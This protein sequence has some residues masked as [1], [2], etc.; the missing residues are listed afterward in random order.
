MGIIYFSNNTML[1]ITRIG[2]HKTRK[3][4]RVGAVEPTSQAGGFLRSLPATCGLA[5]SHP[6]IG[7]DAKQLKKLVACAP[8]R[9][10]GPLRLDEQAAPLSIS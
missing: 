4:V 7:T 10:C 1:Y 2:L 8:L 9:R 5:G 6:R 3:A